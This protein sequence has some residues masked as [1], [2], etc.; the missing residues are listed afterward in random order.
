MTYFK[1]FDPAIYLGCDGG[2]PVHN[3][4]WGNW[5]AGDEP[6]FPSGFALFQWW[7]LCDVIST[8]IQW[9][10]KWPK[11]FHYSNHA[12]ARLRLEFTA[13]LSIVNNLL[14]KYLEIP[15]PFLLES[16][17]HGDAKFNIQTMCVYSLFCL[18]EAIDGIINNISTKASL[19]FSYAN[20]ALELA[21][22]YRKD[23]VNNQSSSSLSAAR[24]Q[25]ARSGAIA[26]L[27][28]D[29]KQKEKSFIYEC[30]LEWKNNPLSYK[31][32]ASF[33]RDMLQKCEHLTSN[34]IIEDWCRDWEK[35]HSA[36]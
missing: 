13:S 22:E 21:H 10:G 33:A 27:A 36:S 31:S 23:A 5:C 16:N 34:K 26:K 14:G 19:G 11:E 18:D 30:W 2:C 9:D 35:A 15:H 1:H 25:F 8:Y 24:A 7:H 20:K 32:K 29:P 6:K 28:K 12:I 3:S 17:L 4:E